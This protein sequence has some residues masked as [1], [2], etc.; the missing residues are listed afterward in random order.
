MLTPKEENN[1]NKQLDEIIDHKIAKN[2]ISGE[3]SWL[4]AAMSLERLY[5]TI[6]VPTKGGKE[7]LVI[8]IK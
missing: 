7:F 5:Q 4:R 6:F 2:I 3:D 8:R 1:T